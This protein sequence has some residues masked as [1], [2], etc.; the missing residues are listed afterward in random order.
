MPGQEGQAKPATGEASDTQMP[1]W[2]G[3][4]GAETGLWRPFCPER[5][6]CPCR[7]CRQM[8]C[9]RARSGPSVPGQSGAD[10]WKETP[11]VRHGQP[12]ACRM[13]HPIRRIPGRARVRATLSTLSVRHSLR[14]ALRTVICQTP[15][16]SA[17]RVSVC[18]FKSP[19]CCH[20]RPPSRGSKA[21]PRCAISLSMGPR[22]KPEDDDGENAHA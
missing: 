22:V 18:L 12:D 11:S 20:P 2:R 5:T 6:E 3:G 17:R 14:A 13:A 19:H 16:L 10:A 4:A 9:P 15:A 7:T 21:K 1:H 8:P